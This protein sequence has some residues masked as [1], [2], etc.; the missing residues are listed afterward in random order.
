MEAAGVSGGGEDRLAAAIRGGVFRGPGRRGARANPATPPAPLVRGVACRRACVPGSVVERLRGGAYGGACFAGRA[1]GGHGPIRP[2]TPCPLVRGE[3]CRRACVPG[4]VVER[5]RGNS[6][7]GVFCWPGRRGARANPAK[8]PLPPC[9]GGALP[10]CLRAGLSSGKT[11]GEFYGGRVLLAGPS[12]GT[13]QSGQK[14]PAPLSGG[15]LADVPACRA[16]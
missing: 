7:G 13:G 16:Q 14:P 11:A 5:L 6:T 10:T 12:G 3:P 4:S 9:Q 15:S 1:A 2:K 8:N